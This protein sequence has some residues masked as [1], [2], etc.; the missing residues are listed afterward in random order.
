MVT[1]AHLKSVL[2]YDPATGEFRWSVSRPGV[3]LGELCGRINQHG[4]REIGVDGGLHQA[5]RLAFL[6]MTGTFP[7]QGVDH[8]NGDR[9]DNR[10]CNL[11]PANQSQ[12]MANVGLRKTNTSGVSGVVWDS[13]RSMWRAQLRVNGKKTNLGR[14]HSMEEA[15]EAVDAAARLQW[16]EFAKWAE[17]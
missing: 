11:R 9:A 17:A 13:D 7:E 8:I 4:Y 2:N 1:Q 6:Y 10:W 3:R 14:F 12:N 16:G 15:K 5:H